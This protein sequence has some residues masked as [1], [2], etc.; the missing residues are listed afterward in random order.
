VA[1]G[2]IEDSG[3]ALKCASLLTGL[4]L[5]QPAS[6]AWMRLSDIDLKTVPMV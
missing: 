6:A 3:G 5:Y 1:L 4:N 2:D